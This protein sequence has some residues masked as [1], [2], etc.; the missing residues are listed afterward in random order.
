MTY[1]YKTTQH[2]HGSR[3]R[4]MITQSR[5]PGKP[6]SSVTTFSVL[7]IFKDLNEELLH[8]CTLLKP[9]S[10]MPQVLR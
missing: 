5:H 7:P 10:P 1:K 6:L 3:L 4:M 9:L 2:P 8:P